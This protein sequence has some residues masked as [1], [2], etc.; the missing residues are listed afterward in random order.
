MTRLVLLQIKHIVNVTTGENGVL[1]KDG[2]NKY[3]L[4]D[5]CQ[6]YGGIVV[7]AETIRESLR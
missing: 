3:T 4:S 2:S 1:V 6:T 7:N 5:V